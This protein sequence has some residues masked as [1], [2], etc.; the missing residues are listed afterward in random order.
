MYP[1]L[2]ANARS[3]AMQECAQKANKMANSAIWHIFF[4]IDKTPF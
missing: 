2:V 4:L 1:A 3:E